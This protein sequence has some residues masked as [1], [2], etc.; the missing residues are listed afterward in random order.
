MLRSLV[1]CAA[2]ALALLPPPVWRGADPP[3]APSLTVARYA[4]AA[5][6][7][8]VP[9][10]RCHVGVWDAPPAKTPTAA[11]LDGPLLGNGDLGAALSEVCFTGR[12]IS[13]SVG[14]VSRSVGP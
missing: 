12:P 1:L 9:R 4:A 8:L 7:S 13:T 5:N 3:R 14:G 10:V 2:G 6:C 11:V